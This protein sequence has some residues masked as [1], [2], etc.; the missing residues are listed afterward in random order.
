MRLVFHTM[1]ASKQNEIFMRV[2][3][4]ASEGPLVC[5]WIWD[6]ICLSLPSLTPSCC[7]HWAKS[8]AAL[9]ALC[10]KRQQVTMADN[11]PLN[12][13][14]RSRSVFFYFRSLLL[15]P[16]R[17]SSFIPYFIHLSFLHGCY[18]HYSNCSYNY[19]CAVTM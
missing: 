17:S 8:S 9:L 12:L 16:H 2:L 7:G 14:T 6:I 15:Q 1:L 10:A 18:G 3:C 19:D 13:C 5:G 11:I 4:K